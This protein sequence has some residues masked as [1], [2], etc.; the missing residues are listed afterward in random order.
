MISLPIPWPE[1]EIDA[2]CEKWLISELSLF[3][4]ILREDFH[5]DSDVDFLV[6]FQPKSKWGLFDRVAMQRELTE[7]LNR[8]VDLIRKRGIERS[9]N[10]IRRNNILSTAKVIYTSQAHV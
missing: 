9:H 2:F 1:K 10:H 4:S 8:E 6:T 3:G 5:P 7:L